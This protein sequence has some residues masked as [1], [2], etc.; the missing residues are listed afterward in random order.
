MWHRWVVL[1]SV[2]SFGAASALA[3]T[4][5]GHEATGNRGSEQAQIKRCVK[6]RAWIAYL[7]GDGGKLAPVR[8]T[9]AEG[10]DQDWLGLRFTDYD[11]PRIRLGVLKVINKSAAAADDDDPHNRRL[12]VPVAGIEEMLTQALYNTKRFDVIEQARISEVE[13]Q[14]A[15]KDILEPSPA[16]I[17]NVGKVLG[18]QY[19]VYGTVNEW[20]PNRSTRKAGWMHYFSSSKREAEVSITFALT[21]V[22]SGQILY[23]T[24]ESARLTNSSISVS[25][26]NGGSGDSGEKSPISYA[27]RA[28]ANK[29]ALR[30]TMFLRNRK[31]KGS[32]VDI[33]GGEVF[34]NGVNGIGC[35]GRGTSR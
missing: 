19:L 30:I 21:D 25:M 29:A 31:W 22:A 2:L 8:D 12:E 4:A 32:I 27:V 6:E 1:V 11:G 14:Q 26:P 9:Q 23:T 15:R 28:C 35:E 24:T 7:R 16:A 10:S 20:T 34:V 17:V 3:L 5:D 13:K 18:A 33:K